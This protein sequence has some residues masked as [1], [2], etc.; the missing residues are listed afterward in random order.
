MQ[1]YEKGINGVSA[2]RLA[3][4]A[5]R[6]NTPVMFF[7]GGVGAKPKNDPRN[8]SL[9]FV[10]TKGAMRLLRAYA[11]IGSRTTKYALIVLAESLRN[12]D[13]TR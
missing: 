6:L 5:D 9:A 11:E 13:R 3:R 4:I 10:Q 12:K 7:Y 2:G 8:S 1:K